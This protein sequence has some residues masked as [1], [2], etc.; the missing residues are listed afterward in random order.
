MGILMTYGAHFLW[1]TRSIHGAVDA[2]SL[3][4]AKDFFVMNGTFLTLYWAVF[5]AGIHLLRKTGEETEN[6][7][8][9]ANIGNALF[10]GSS[11]QADFMSIDDG[12]KMLLTANRIHIKA[13]NDAGRLI[14]IEAGNVD[15]GR[16]NGTLTIVSTIDSDIIP[17]ADVT[18]KLGDTGKG[19]IFYGNG[20]NLTG[21]ATSGALTAYVLKA[22]DTM[23][24]TLTYDGS[25]LYG[26]RSLTSNA[27]GAAVYGE[28]TATTGSHYGG[29]FKTDGSSTGFFWGKQRHDRWNV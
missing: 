1:V 10:M 16:L 23:T 26:I 11:T 2:A 8:A 18:Y 21:V 3:T 20:S 27:T 9:V 12:G 7:L 15:I 13:D 5:T 14:T 4:A 24:G 29:Y 6:Q 19:W 17:A 25:S 28:S 22:G